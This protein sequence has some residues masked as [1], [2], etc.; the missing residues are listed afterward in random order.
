MI[1]VDFSCFFV[2]E[3]TFTFISKRLN[4]MEWYKRVGRVETNVYLK[5]ITHYCDL[6]VWSGEDKFPG[7][8]L[9]HD[10]ESFGS[11]GHSV[12]QQCVYIA[13]LHTF[14]LICVYYNTVLFNSA[15][16]ELKVMFLWKFK[17][18]FYSWIFQNL[19]T[20]SSIGTAGSV[21]VSAWLGKGLLS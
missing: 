14:V 21:Y 20:S 17:K 1:Y 11:K 3:D 8:K 13:T 15:Q 7:N 2:E 9:F 19:W 6:M 10:Y 18:I 16:F 12:W 4:E 5:S